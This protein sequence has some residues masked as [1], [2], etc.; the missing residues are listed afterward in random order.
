MKPLRYIDGV[1]LLIRRARRRR[2][3]ADVAAGLG[4]GP[5]IVALWMLLSLI[6]AH[7]AEIPPDIRTALSHADDGAVVLESTHADC[8]IG[9]ST[10]RVVTDR[11]AVTACWAPDQ[12]MRPVITF[13]RAKVRLHHA[14]PVRRFL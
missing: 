6:P 7:S 8:P 9:Y 13:G 14:P 11:R 10:A 4:L 12:L 2:I 5:A 1:D 3:A